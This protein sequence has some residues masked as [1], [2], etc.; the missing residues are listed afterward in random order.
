M[1]PCAGAC[2]ADVLNAGLDLVCMCRDMFQHLTHC[3]QEIANQARFSSAQ[4]YITAPTCT[5]PPQTP[6]Q[7]QQTYKLKRGL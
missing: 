1:Q 3:D 6:M 4:Q 7:W 5:A 2:A